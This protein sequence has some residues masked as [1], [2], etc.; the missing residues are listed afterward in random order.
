MLQWMIA[1]TYSGALDQLKAYGVCS[2]VHV[3]KGLPR[4]DIIGL[5]QTAVQESKQRV[6]S[7]I[8]N[9]GL[10]LGPRKIIVNLAP[11]SQKKEGTQFDLSVAVG[12]LVGCGLTDL[13]AH[14]DRVF[15]GELS[16]DGEIKKVHACLAIIKGLKALGFKNFAIP[17]ANLRE[18]QW[19]SDIECIGFSTLSELLQYFTSH[20]MPVQ[21]FE[22]SPS[23]TELLNPMDWSDVKGQHGAKRA[24]EIAAA[25]GHNVLLK[26]PPGVGKTLLAQRFTHILPPLSL[27][28]QAQIQSLQSILGIEIEKSPQ[29]PVR[30]PHH[31]ISLA[32]MMGGGRPFRMGECSRAHLGVLFLDE[33]PEFRRDVIEALREPLESKTFHISRAQGA[34]TLPADFQ[35]IAAMNL[36]PC[37]AMG[38]QSLSCSCN[39]SAVY[40]YQR[41]IS[42][43]ILDRI[44]LHVMMEK[45]PWKH[46]WEQKSGETGHEVQKRVIQARKLQSQRLGEGLCN[47]N[48]SHDQIKKFVQLDSETETLLD[49]AVEKHGLSARSMIHLLKVTRSIADL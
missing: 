22:A 10:S 17:M 44:S 40:R 32:G 24:L 45:V 35:L 49:R 5:A 8:E 13:G 48:M 27:Q 43:P 20:Q 11:A 21:S 3:E 29:R 34:Y 31:S 37:G 41:K 4:F 46:I 42:G 25:G 38:D 28:D 47:A 15:L 14:S 6:L 18:S 2:E 30:S 12:L 36:C 9:T 26:G 19:I 1:R 7:A 39:P 16:L 33:F 23:K